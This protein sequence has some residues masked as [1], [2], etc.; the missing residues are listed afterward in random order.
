LTALLALPPAHAIRPDRLS[1]RARQS[2]ASSC[3]TIGASACCSPG[4]GDRLSLRGKERNYA[5]GL[6]VTGL[7][8]R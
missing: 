3:P 1:R 5:F 7:S 6:A 4:A 8:L 2:F